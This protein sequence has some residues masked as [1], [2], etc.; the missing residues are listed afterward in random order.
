MTGIRVKFRGKMARIMGY[1]GE[2]RF[3]ILGSD[4]S[5]YVAHRDQL[6]FVSRR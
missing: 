2:N 5:R 1:L 6:V 4:D 3:D